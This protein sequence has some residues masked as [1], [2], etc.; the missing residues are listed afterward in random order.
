MQIEIEADRDHPRGG[1]ARVSLMPA[2]AAEGPLAVEVKNSFNGQFLGEDGWQPTRV[3]FGP[4]PLQS[5]EDGSYLVLGPEIVDQIEEYTQLELIIAGSSAT[6]SWPDDIAKAPASARRGGIASFSAQGQEKKEDR[7]KAPVVAPPPPPPPGQ[8]MDDPKTGGDETADGSG[9]E[10]VEGTDETDETSGKSRKAM[11]AVGGILL[12]LAALAAAYFLLFKPE[13]E[14]EPTPEPEPVAAVEP[15]PDPCGAE[16]IEAL[17]GGA[18][19]ESRQVL[20]QCGG[21]VTPDMALSIVDAAAE[22]SDAEALTL[23][24][25]LYD[26][27]VEDADFEAGIGLTFPAADYS[28]AEYYSRAVAAGSTEAAGLLEQTCTRLADDTAS[29][30]Q[31]ALEEYCP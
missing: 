21:A 8:G 9:Q 28:A 6:T 12:L 25:K 31:N 18:F 3:A 26:G 16:A 2:P 14:P 5:D 10:P 4:Y 24:G 23:Y 15:A 11:F 20:A 17:R 19:A 22:G 29:L 7:L 13:P 30:A 1:F 27:T